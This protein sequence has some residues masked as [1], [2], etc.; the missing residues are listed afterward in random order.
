MLQPTP[1]PSPPPSPIRSPTS[2]AE[3][4]ERKLTAE[5][6]DELQR[7]AAAEADRLMGWQPTPEQSPGSAYSA[8]TPELE[9][10]RETYDYLQLCLDT[11]IDWDIPMV[12][13]SSL[14][15]APSRYGCYRAGQVV[16][17]VGDA[18]T[19]TVDI[20]VG[21]AIATFT[22]TT[23]TMAQARAMQDEGQ[24]RYLIQIADDQVLDCKLTATARPPQCWASNA[25]QAQGLVLH[26][27]RLTVNHNNA[28]AELLQTAEGI[29]TATLYAVV[30]IRAHE[31]IM[32]D[33]GE[34]FDDGFE[35]PEPPPS[36]QASDHASE[37]EG[38]KDTSVPLHEAVGTRRSARLQANRPRLTDEEWDV[39]FSHLDH[40]SGDDD[41]AE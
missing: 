20:A 19:A 12:P 26:G 8:M 37:K 31:D 21:Q 2:P 9:E 27:R 11:V 6:F 28:A 29:W 22:G 1:S 7:E 25:N 34:E 5:E 41:E 16:N 15:V 40:E 23:L 36:G 14:R 10:E 39:F 17:A 32:W 4:L 38:E 35:Q 30:P 18:L 33:Y 3:A 13:A 24:G